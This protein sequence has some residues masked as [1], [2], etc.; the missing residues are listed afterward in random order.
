M[1]S[2]VIQW[3]MHTSKTF[4]DLSCYTKVVGQATMDLCG[5]QYDD[6]I[7]A[8]YSDYSKISWPMMAT[9]MVGY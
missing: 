6:H 7:L 3:T 2:Q 9:F 4:P 8:I 5:L 1:D